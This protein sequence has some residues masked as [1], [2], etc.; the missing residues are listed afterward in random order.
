MD[1]KTRT[2]KHLTKQQNYLFYFLIFL[3]SILPF[4][5]FP[6]FFISSWITFYRHIR[7]IIVAV[8]KTN[9]DKLTDDLVE[10]II[11]KVSIWNGCLGI[12]LTK[13]PNYV[14]PEPLMAKIPFLTYFSG[15]FTNVKPMPDYNR[16]QRLYNHSYKTSQHYTQQSNQR[17]NDRQAYRRNYR[18]YG[19]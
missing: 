11:K 2:I 3:C 10:D 15:L 16:G 4:T 14:P 18:K 12:D 7:A 8:G 5:F 19:S 9:N 1:N 13:I 17:A 6:I